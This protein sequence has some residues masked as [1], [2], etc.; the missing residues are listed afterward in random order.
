MSVILTDPPLIFVH[1]P[2]TAGTSITRA[3]HDAGFAPTSALLQGTGV[4]SMGHHPTA[5]RVQATLEAVGWADLY[6]AA[7]VF[8]VV[9]HPFDRLL[10]FWHYGRARLH[11]CPFDSFDS[12]LRFVVGDLDVRCSRSWRRARLS[13]LHYMDVRID[14]VL[15][16]ENL[17]AS[18][19]RLV[20]RQG[21][22]Q[23]MQALPKMKQSRHRPW[24]KS[25][26][27]HQAGRLYEYVRPEMDELGYDLHKLIAVLDAERV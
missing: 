6:E 17:G 19:A 22:P 20:H 8:T 10:S 24:W 27:A 21:L 2:K 16:F 18:W 26:T 23:K 3:F 15:R 1:I 11:P 25:Y 5:S 9:R 13:Q 4:R 7:H 12:F 14:E